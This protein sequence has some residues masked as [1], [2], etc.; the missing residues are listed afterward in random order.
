MATG[1]NITKTNQALSV[2]KNEQPHHWLLA[3]VGVLILI[4]VVVSALMIRFEIVPALFVNRGVEAAAARYQGLADYYIYRMNHESIH[5]SDNMT[6]YYQSRVNHLLGREAADPL[7]ISA[8]ASARLEG[9]AN[10]YKAK[11]EAQARRSQ[12]ATSARLTGLANYY[13]T[14]G[15]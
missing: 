10:A 4:A 2:P 14:K 11:I 15:D 12:Q 3:A 7:R 8:A 9:M 5:L 13:L 6:T 1:V